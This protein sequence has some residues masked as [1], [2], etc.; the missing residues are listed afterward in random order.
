MSVI[1]GIV[2]AL[3]RFTELEIIQDRDLK[4]SIVVFTKRQWNGLRGKKGEYWTTH[5]EINLINTTLDR[6]IS[7]IE[8][9]FGITT[10][11][12][13]ARQRLNEERKIRRKSFGI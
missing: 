3:R 9:I 12:E 2:G 5:E 4:Q 7:H 6:V 13:K 11:W 10:D 1:N 8:T